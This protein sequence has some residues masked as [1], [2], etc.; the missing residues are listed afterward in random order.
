MVTKRHITATMVSRARNAVPRPP[1]KGVMPI[2]GEAECGADHNVHLGWC[3]AVA[4]GDRVANGV[5]G[6]IGTVGQPSLALS[7]RQS[8]RLSSMGASIAD[9]PTSMPATIW[10]ALVNLRSVPLA[11]RGGTQTR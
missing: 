3:A 5:D 2:R 4:V 8:K 1:S 7:M 10:E 6:W 11:T 9:L